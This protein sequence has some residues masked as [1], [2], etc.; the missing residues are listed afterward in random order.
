MWNWFKR[1]WHIMLIV[2]ILSALMTGLFI[3]TDRSVEN[4]KNEI[5][6]VWVK[7]TGNP[8][9]L[10]RDEFFVLKQSCDIVI[11]INKEEK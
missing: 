4:R 6:R 3:V 2:V 1:T 8:K 11:N 7:Q 10:T 9:N 5:Y